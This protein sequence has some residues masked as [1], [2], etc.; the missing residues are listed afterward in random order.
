MTKYFNKK[1]EKFKRRELRKNL[2]KA[3]EILW[4]HLKGKQISGFRFRRQYSIDKFVIDFYCPKVKLA[5]ELDGSGHEEDHM[6]IYDNHREEIIRSL[7]VTFL[8][9]KNIEIFGNL[10]KV[11]NNI[12]DKLNELSSKDLPRHRACLS[13]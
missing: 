4:K 13:V 12:S 3:E 2:T 8:R 11:L 9:F 6:H 7:E 10:E 5:I 1:S